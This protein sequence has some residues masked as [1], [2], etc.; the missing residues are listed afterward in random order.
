MFRFGG[1]DF[2]GRAQVYQVG[3]GGK[4]QIPG[5]EAYRSG[6]GYGPLRPSSRRR[7]RKGSHRDEASQDPVGEARP[8]SENEKEEMDGK[9]NRQKKKEKEIKYYPNDPNFISKSTNAASY[10]I[11][12]FGS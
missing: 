6:I 11:L 8:G 10:K 9:I 5:S 4:E 12:I 1:N 2:Q 3:K 7:R